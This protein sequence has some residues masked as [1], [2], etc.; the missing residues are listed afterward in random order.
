MPA[1]FFILLSLAPAFLE[2]R[3]DTEHFSIFHRPENELVARELAVEVEEIRA[4][5]QADLGTRRPARARVMLAVDYDDM[6]AAAPSGVKVPVWAAGMAFSR[7]NLILLRIKGSSPREES[8]VEVFAHEWAH[9]A[10]AHA[11]A[12]RPVPRWFN[13][14]FAMYEADQWSFS[15]A[16]TLASAV[17]SDRLFSLETLTDSFPTRLDDVSLAYAQSID[18]ISFLLEEY[19]Q[20]RFH[21]LIRLLAEDWTFLS[22]LKEAYETGLHVLEKKWRE[23]LKLRFTWIPLITGT[24]TLWFLATL[25]FLLAYIK[26]RKRKLAGFESLDDDDDPLPPKDD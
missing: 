23:D 15:R 13:E 4:R 16:G 2:A 9:V 20:K 22:A 10:L 8:I 11:T 21:R 12:F 6:Q 5:I 19:G 24:A 3:L 18:F 25:I 7:L 26:K 17:I 1:I 14:G